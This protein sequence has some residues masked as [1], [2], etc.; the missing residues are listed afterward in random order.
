MKVA[1][2]EGR[3]DA[4][5]WAMLAMLLMIVALDQLLWRPIV[6]WA[7]KFR[8]EEGG[9]AAGH[10]VVVLELAATFAIVTLDTTNLSRVISQGSP[11]GRGGQKTD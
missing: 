4:M 1:V 6:V 10:V 9:E 8:V 2:D 7:Q 5:L 3:V 11:D